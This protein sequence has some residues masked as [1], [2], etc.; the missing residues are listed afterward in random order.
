M[1]AKSFYRHCSLG[2]FPFTLECTF[3]I[4]Y[5]PTVSSRMQLDDPPLWNAIV[6]EFPWGWNARGFEIA[7]PSR[8]TA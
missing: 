1:V 7:K 5:R 8:H 2:F 6:C 3:Q 4:G